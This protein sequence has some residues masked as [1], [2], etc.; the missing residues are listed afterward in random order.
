M[1][2]KIKIGGLHLQM[3]I[4]EQR[5]YIKLLNLTLRVNTYSLAGNTNLFG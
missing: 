4:A 1:P 3:T 5:D 2:P